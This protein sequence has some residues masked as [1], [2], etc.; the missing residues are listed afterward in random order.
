[1]HFKDFW[2]KA[3][4]RLRAYR[5]QATRG[6]IKIQNDT[7]LFF[8]FQ[9]KYT[10]NPKYI[11]RRLHEIAPALRCVWVVLNEAD[12]AEFPD[13]VDTVLFGTRDY[14]RALYGAKVLVDNG[15]NFVKLPFTKKK[16]QY[17]VETMHGSLGIKRID[18][19]SNP[20]PKR[21]RIGFRCGAL[22]DYIISNSD[23]ENEVYRS[24]FW[25]KTPILLYGHPRNDILIRGADDS[26]DGDHNLRDK[27]RAFYGLPSDAKLALYAPT[28][29]R[30]ASKEFEEFDAEHLR[31][32]LTARF[33]GD[34]YILKR[35][36]PR[37]CRNRTVRPDR[38]FI[39]NGNLYTDIQEMMV[40]IDFAVTDYSSW[41]FDYVVTKKPG[42][43]YAPD[44]EEYQNST[45]FYYPI[46]AAPFPLATDNASVSELI[47]TFD[48]EKY[49]EEVDLF[50][51]GK[52]CVDDGKASER[53]AAMLRNLTRDKLPE[54]AE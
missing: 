33:G 7:V 21:N 14:F 42:M 40:A 54:E 8:T 34:W 12:R 19:S 35:L 28:F 5:Y 51:E 48:M 46:T 25:E 23:F 9:G 29:A 20:D 24:S 45:G 13:Y 30:E 3:T 16:G 38:A 17:Y 50:L 4:R 11:C 26:P 27:V 53:A 2:K 6:S 44:L 22:C 39:L 47:G 36:H 10:C 31:D 43:I 52:G 49:S 37:D 32:C 15:F 18:A 1:M 41:I